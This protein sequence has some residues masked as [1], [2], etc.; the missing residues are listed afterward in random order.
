MNEYQEFCE[1]LF[2]AGIFEKVPYLNA[3][4][5][6]ALTDESYLLKGERIFSLAREKKRKEQLKSQN[7]TVR[8]CDLKFPSLNHNEV[9]AHKQLSNS[10]K[11][12]I[13]Q[14]FKRINRNEKYSSI[15]DISFFFYFQISCQQRIFQ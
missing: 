6:E 3:N 2:I 5:D 8:L 10:I 4:L 9:E 15:E 7:L 13:R 1:L 14:E 12:F 11:K